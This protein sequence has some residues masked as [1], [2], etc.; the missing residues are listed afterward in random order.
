MANLQSPNLPTPEQPAAEPAISRFI[1]VRHGETTWNAEQRIQG[2]LDAEL[3]PLG[4]EQARRVARHLSP[5]PFAA[6]YSSDLSRARETAAVVA[7]QIG[8]AVQLERGFREASFGEWEGLTVAEIRARFPE[9]YR[10]WR[11]DA[12]SHRPQ[13]G[14]TIQ[15][16]QG[17]GIKWEGC[18]TALVSHP[19]LLYGS[20]V[21]AM[22]VWITSS[23]VMPS[24]KPSKLRM[25]R[26]RN[27]G[28][29]IVRRSS[30]ETL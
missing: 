4:R 25:M 16:L 29:A 21:S 22:T 24:A 12:I 20:G 6:I 3:S 19:C 23:G 5:E 17:I 2:Q 28:K 7:A 8:V 18:S 9:E 15:A 11:Q 13:G 30:R 27:A 1:L 10:L 26:C 14:E